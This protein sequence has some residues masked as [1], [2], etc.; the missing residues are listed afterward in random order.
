V[1]IDKRPKIVQ[2]SIRAG[3]IEADFMMGKNYKGAKL[4]MTG[5]ATM[6]TSLHRL[7]NRHSEVVSKSIIMRLRELAI[8]CIL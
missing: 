3:D 5:G 6:N 2:K 1:P 8:L 7:D 4:M